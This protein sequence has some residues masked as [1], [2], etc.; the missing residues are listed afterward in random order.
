MNGFRDYIE[1]LK[2]KISRIYL[3]QEIVYF[4]YIFKYSIIQ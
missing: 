4:V 1:Y 3:K 2:S